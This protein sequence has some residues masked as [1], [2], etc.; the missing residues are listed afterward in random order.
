MEGSSIRV[1]AGGLLAELSDDLKSVED[2][3]RSHP[4]LLSLERGNVSKD[5]LRAFAGEQHAIVSSD[6]RSFAFAA[7]RFSTGKAG[8]LLLALAQ[9]EG[10]ALTKLSLFARWL[11]LTEDELRRYEPR[12]RAQAYPSYVA[13]LALN[14][15]PSDIAFAFAANLDAWGAN[16]ARMA[17]ALRTTYESDEDTTAF[18]DYF[19]KPPPELR[20][21][22][23]AVVDEGLRAGDSPQCARRAARLLQTFEL[24]FWDAV[25][26][27]S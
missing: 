6:R 1:T 10:V 12:A 9:G 11:D 20:D 4:F 18:F 3:I 17:Q 16:C 19:G 22:L 26:Q 21:G 7:S 25:A 23:L 14:G 5:Q 2:A 15:S 8:D 27:V 13:W 24:D